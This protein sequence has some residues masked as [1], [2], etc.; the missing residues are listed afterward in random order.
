MSLFSMHEMLQKAQKEGYAVGAFNV[1]NME[2]IQA[3]IAAAEEL[4]APVIIQT[5]PSTIKY[6][7]PRLFAANVSALVDSARIPVALHLDHGDSFALAAQ[8]L[9]AGYSSVMIDGSKLPLDENIAITKSVVSLCRPCGISVEG[10]LGAIG[11]KEDGI[12]GEMKYTDPDE[13][14]LFA[15]QT[16]VDALAVAIGTAHGI[17]KETPRLNVE[18]LKQIREKTSV[19]LVLHGTSGLNGEVVKECISN[20]ICKVN[21]ATD[22]RIAFSNGIKEYLKEHDDV[23]D[24]KKYNAHA[25]QMVKKCAMEKILICN[26][27]YKA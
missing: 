15:S 22:L 24:P 3:V 16:G 25:R 8:S 19:P 26:A 13:S 1:E 4:N 23:F 14:A 9:H 6:A 18:R 2:M 11:G 27:S 20:G 10:E 21:Y 5:T 17:Y 12:E 7:S